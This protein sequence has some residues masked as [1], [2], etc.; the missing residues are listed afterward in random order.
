MWNECVYIYYIYIFSW[1]QRKDLPLPGGG[2]RLGEMGEG[3]QKVK[4][5]NCKINQM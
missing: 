4:T 3:G 5:F 1:K 2:G